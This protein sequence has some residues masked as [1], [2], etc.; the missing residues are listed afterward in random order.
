MKNK[1]F[2]GARFL[3]V[4]FFISIE[5]INSFLKMWK[6]SIVVG[7]VV[8]VDLWVKWVRV[9]VLALST[10]PHSFTNQVFNGDSVVLWLRFQSRNA[11]RWQ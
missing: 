2:V 4:K 9:S 10:N 5:K 8:N 3:F 6:I 1:N 7:V 11:E